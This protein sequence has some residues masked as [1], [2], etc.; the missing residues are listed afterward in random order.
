MMNMFTN[1]NIYQYIYIYI[2]IGWILAPGL[3]LVFAACTTSP[4]ANASWTTWDTACQWL[5]ENI[6]NIDWVPDKTECPE[7]RQGSRC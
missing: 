5:S 3:V 4:G 6:Q 1:I 2:M 7:G